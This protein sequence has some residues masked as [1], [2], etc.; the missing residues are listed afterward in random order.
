[1]SNTEKH[2]PV[3]TLVKL[4]FI[5][6][7]DKPIASLVFNTTKIAITCK[8]LKDLNLFYIN[9]EYELQNVIVSE[10][11]QSK[12]I[13]SVLSFKSSSVPDNLTS[14]L[15]VVILNSES[16][17]AINYQLDTSSAVNL[18]NEIEMTILQNKSALE[19]L[20]RWGLSTR[21]SN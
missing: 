9:D 4:S 11:E 6:A 17:Q 14:E 3:T 1:M 8:Q 13:Q 19:Q 15:A 7:Q 10:N 21:L 2:S 12:I 20:K 18:Y 5:G 16:K